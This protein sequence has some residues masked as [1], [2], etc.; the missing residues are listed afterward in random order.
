[1]MKYVPV[2]AARGVLDSA[3]YG[4]TESPGM[5]GFARTFLLDVLALLFSTI[6]IYGRNI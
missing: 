3:I 2:D 4:L 5:S 6:C 1:M